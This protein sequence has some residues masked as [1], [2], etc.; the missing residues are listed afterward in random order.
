M[1]I[2]AYQAWQCGGG[3]VELTERVPLLQMDFQ[4]VVHPLAGAADARV[5]QRGTCHAVLLWMEY[6]LDPEGTLQVRPAGA[7]SGC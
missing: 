3:Y 7:H 5:L 1:P 2:L 4:R 6:D